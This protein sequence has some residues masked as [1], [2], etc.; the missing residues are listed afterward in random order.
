MGRWDNRDALNEKEKR[1]LMV[2]GSPYWSSQH[3]EHETYVQ[4]VLEL[5]EQLYPELEG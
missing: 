1:E 4:R 2:P 5:N 3:P